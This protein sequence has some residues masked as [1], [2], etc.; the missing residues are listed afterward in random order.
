MRQAIAAYLEKRGWAMRE[1]IREEEGVLPVVLGGDIKAYWA[2]GPG[3]PRSGVRAGLFH[4]TTGYSLPEAVSLAEEI[5][6]HQPLGSEE[7]YRL[8]RS[9]SLALWRRGR[10]FRALNRMLFLA[11][12]PADRYRVL[13]H[14]YRLPEPV[15]HRFYAGKSTLMDKFRILSGKAPVPVG[16]ALRSLLSGSGGL[17]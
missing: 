1:L 11:A 16:P 17:R 2:A 4:F 3:V 5:A 8:V 7:L 6:A 13:Q 10:F 12:G 15:I 14:F 9:R